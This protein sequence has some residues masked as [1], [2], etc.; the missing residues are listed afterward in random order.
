MLAETATP[1]RGPC[2]AARRC[3]ALAYSGS[4][5]IAYIGLGGNL[6]SPAGPPATTLAAAVRRLGAIG[7]VTARSRLY[8]TE[9]VGLADQPRFANAVAALETAI[10][11][12]DLLDALLAIEREFGRDRRAGIANGPRTLDLD[13]LLYGN[14]VVQEPGL[15]IPHPRLAERAFVL[16]PLSEIAPEARDPRTGATVAQCLQR[17][18]FACPGA[19]NAVLPFQDDL[20]SAE[21]RLDGGG[22]DAGFRHDR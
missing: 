16:I 22:S 10:G 19:G 21:S 3:R 17:L 9:P 2:R 12:R 6:P 1:G 5:A 11:S 20:W 13:L 18:L 8:S 15:E 4:V 7:R 14:E